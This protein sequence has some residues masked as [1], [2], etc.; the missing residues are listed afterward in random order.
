MLKR[1]AG[2]LLFFLLFVCVYPSGKRDIMLLIIPGNKT[3]PIIHIVK[4]SDLCYI[5]IHKLK[6]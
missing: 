4:W 6:I 3:R 1:N 5:K 2:I